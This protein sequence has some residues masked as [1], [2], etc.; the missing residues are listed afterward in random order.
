MLCNA[1]SLDR[2]A[3][4]AFEAPHCL[5]FFPCIEHLCFLRKGLLRRLC[6]G[7][8]LGAATR[9]NPRSKGAFIVTGS[10]TVSYDFSAKRPNA[11]PPSERRFLRSTSHG[12]V[13]AASGRARNIHLRKEATCANRWVGS[14]QDGTHTPQEDRVPEA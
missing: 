6:Q 1:A 9:S 14:A 13:T 3:T 4:G 12:G 5:W 8:E 7:P 10:A 2:G 11:T